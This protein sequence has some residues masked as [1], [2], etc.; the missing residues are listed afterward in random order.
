M[1]KTA[2]LYGGS[3][4]ELAAEE[5]LA[6]TIMGEMEEVEK[7]FKENPDYLRLLGEPSIPKAER[8]SLLDKAFGG[9]I[10]LYLMN[11]LKLLCEN[12]TLGEFGGCRREMIRR[13]NEDNNIAEAVVTSAVPHSGEQTEALKRKLESL[14]HKTIILTQKTDSR[15]MG[16]LKVE[17]EGRELDGTVE[18]RLTGLR[19]KV[20]EIIM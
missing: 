13:Y 20:S 10:E 7:I 8:V 14:S 17:L 12:G 3:L 6:E 2:R 5:N 18:G 15:V 9:Q 11:F 4:Y 1:T 19:K 16:G